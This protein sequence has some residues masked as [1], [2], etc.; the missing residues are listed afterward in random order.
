MHDSKSHLDPSPNYL[1]PVHHSKKP[2]QRPKKSHS[3][4][5]SPL[6]TVFNTPKDDDSSSLCSET[7]QDSISGTKKKSK[8]HRL[9]RGAYKYKKDDKGA[10]SDS[11]FQEIRNKKQYKIRR[12]ALKG[13]IELPKFTR[14]GSLN[15]GKE[16]KKYREHLQRKSFRSRSAVKGGDKNYDSD[17]EDE[18][19]IRQK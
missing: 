7:S 16:S 9:F 1:S 18:V 8:A 2:N 12:D 5:T 13:S 6:H 11:E 14:G 3:N 15:L 4:R 10:L 17:K 19:V